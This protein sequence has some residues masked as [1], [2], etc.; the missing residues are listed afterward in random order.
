MGSAI[1]SHF[2]GLETVFSVFG[3]CDWPELWAVLPD[4]TAQYGAVLGLW[5]GGG[6]R[7]LTK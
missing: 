2:G 7:P 5:S 3:V 4:Q 1:A 6:Y